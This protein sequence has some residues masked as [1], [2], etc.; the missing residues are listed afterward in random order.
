MGGWTAKIPRC[1]LPHLLFMQ[2]VGWYYSGPRSRNQHACNFRQ[3]STAPLGN[4]QSSPW[5]RRKHGLSCRSMEAGTVVQTQ[6]S[7]AREKGTHVRPLQGSR[8]AA[9]TKIIFVAS[10]S[11]LPTTQIPLRLKKRHHETIILT[12]GLKAGQ[13]KTQITVLSF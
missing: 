2:P 11:V 3:L 1:V 5:G 12:V 8:N 4:C 10:S 9:L 6:A 13:K 7:Q